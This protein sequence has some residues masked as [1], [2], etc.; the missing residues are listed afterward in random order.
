MEGSLVAT[1]SLYTMYA[2]IE[3]KP[4]FFALEINKNLN[5]YII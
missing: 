4:L 5:P 3:A 1:D 2:Q